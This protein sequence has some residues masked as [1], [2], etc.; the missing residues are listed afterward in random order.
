M[1]PQCCE[2]PCG[3]E[4]FAKLFLKS[5]AIQQKNSRKDICTDVIERIEHNPNFQEQVITSNEYCI[6]ECIQKHTDYHESIG[7]YF[8]Q[9]IVKPQDF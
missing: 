1:L 3:N 8:T 5:L 4:I 9:Q 7:H 6:F 2:K